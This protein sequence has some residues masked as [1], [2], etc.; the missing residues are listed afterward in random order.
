MCPLQL[1]L[2][3]FGENYQNLVQMTKKFNSIFRDTTIFDHN[4]LSTISYI[5]FL[6][7]V[8]LGHHSALDS[9]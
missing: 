1:I 2:A 5:H 3:L 7:T 4:G 6:S 8:I 9:G